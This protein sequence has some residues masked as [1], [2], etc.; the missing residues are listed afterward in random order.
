MPSHFKTWYRSLTADGKVWAETSD[1][2]DPYLLNEREPVTFQRLDIYLTDDGW[3]PWT[4][5]H[6]EPLQRDD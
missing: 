2:T 3:H 4:P 6:I 1:P 5:G